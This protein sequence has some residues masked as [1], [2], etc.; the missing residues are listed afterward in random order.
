MDFDKPIVPR[1]REFKQGTHPLDKV[2]PDYLQAPE[3]YTAGSIP[4]TPGD[5]PTGEQQG[6]FPTGR[7]SD[8][9][10]INPAVDRPVPLDYGKEAAAGMYQGG[11][12]EE[13]LQDSLDLLAHHAGQILDIV[14]KG[15]REQGHMKET[16][17]RYAKQIADL[18]T[19]EEFKFTTFEATSDEM[20]VLAPV[21]FYTL[22]AHHVIPFYGHAY[23]GYVPNELIAGL[24]KFGRLVKWAAKGLWV[25]EE[26][27]SF[28]A[29][30]I[31]SRLRPRGV[32]V[33]L[34]GEHLCMA[35]RGVEMPGVVTTTSSMRGVF[36]DHTRTAKAEFMQ[37]I[38]GKRRHRG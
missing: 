38:E 9:K 16:P 27:T 11:Y 5:L 28:I 8:G 20:I 1:G 35:M 24:S 36:G 18:T 34:E 31:E 23:I 25:Q 19:R 2:K 30:E 33:I 21:P 29:Q 6:L 37:L 4:W 32:A 17:L 14:A 13:P 7:V 10:F 22:C 15:W 26:L 3:G 12:T